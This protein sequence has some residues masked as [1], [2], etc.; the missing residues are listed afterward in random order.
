[1]QL[2]RRSSA[3][4]SSIG[5]N[6][7][8]APAVRAGV[9]FA[10]S[11]MA[12]WGIAPQ[13]P[14]TTSDISTS[15]R[16]TSHRRRAS[17]PNRPGSSSYAPSVSEHARAVII[18]GG[19]GGTSIAYHLTELGWKDV[20]LVD[21]AELTSRLDVPLGGARRPAAVEH[22]PDP[23]DDVRRG[24][25]PAPD[26]RDRRRRVVARGRLAAARIDEGALRGAAAPGGLGED[27][28]AAARP[29]LRR[30]GA[31]EVPADDARRRPRRRLAADRR[32]ARPV[33]AGAGA[34]GG[35]ALPWRHDPP[36]HAGRRHRRRAAGA[37]AASRSR[38]RTA[39]ARRS[40]PTSSS[41][42]AACSRR[43]SGAWRA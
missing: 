33:R 7:S 20:V 28:R 14:A 6:S 39:S 43:R 40:R 27:L 37:S 21:R 8:P 23:D 36:A 9:G 2:A 31:G 22:D 26:C 41:T 17:G 30:G 11:P 25:V 5:T 13:H 15:A 10:A 42:P 19:V 12:S 38:R 4:Q 35:C 32:L 3:S 16:R 34:R 29:H 1:M 24:A 18:G